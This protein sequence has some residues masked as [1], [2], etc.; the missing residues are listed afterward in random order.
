M[1]WFEHVV[2]FSSQIN[3][4]VGCVRLRIPGRFK[5]RGPRIVLRMLGGATWESP[6]PDRVMS[7][8]QIISRMLCGAVLEAT[9]PDRAQ[10][11]PDGFQ[12]ALRNHF[13][14]SWRRSG[15]GS[16]R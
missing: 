10:D 9:C 6:G 4:N 3:E 11:D 1:L 2:A 7:E 5:P 8:P 14:A 13:G 15:P 12:K 16:P